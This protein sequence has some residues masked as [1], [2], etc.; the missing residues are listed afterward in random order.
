[1]ECSDDG[2]DIITLPVSSAQHVQATGS[3]GVPAS[4][5]ETGLNYSPIIVD[6]FIDTID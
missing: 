3:A 1:L 6:V 5:V 2:G 4:R